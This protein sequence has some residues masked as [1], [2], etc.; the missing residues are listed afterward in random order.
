MGQFDVNPAGRSLGAKE[1]GL[2]VSHGAHAAPGGDE[3]PVTVT[4]A[5]VYWLPVI[6]ALCVFA[7]VAVLG[8]RPALLEERRLADATG[9]LVGRYDESVEESARLSRLLRAQKDPVLL[10][11]ERRALR[12]DPKA[13]G[14]KQ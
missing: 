2:P 14:Q 6:V 5:L 3:A 11:R 8:L 10:E 7:Q 13:P 9:T 1:P 12:V 4:R